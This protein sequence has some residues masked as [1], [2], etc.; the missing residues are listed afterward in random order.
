MTRRCSGPPGRSPGEAKNAYNAQ[1]CATR[2]ACLL[3]PSCMVSLM[4]FSKGN[5]KLG[6]PSPRNKTNPEVHCLQGLNAAA[7]GKTQGRSALG[8]TTAGPAIPVLESPLHTNPS[9]GEDPRRGPLL[10]ILKQEVTTSRPTV[11]SPSWFGPSSGDMSGSSVC[12]C[13]T[14]AYMEQ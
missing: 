1:R 11:I 2:F 14:A 4:W 7:D 8:S 10:L 5:R 6:Y 12:H 13:P 3:P 9:G